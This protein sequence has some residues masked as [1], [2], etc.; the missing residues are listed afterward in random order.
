MMAPDDTRVALIMAGSKGLGLGC[1]EAL[2]SSGFRIAICARGQDGVD[3]A[4]RDLRAKG[5]EVIG[6]AA[7]VSR[8]DELASVFDVLDE[9][10]GRLD[11]LVVNAGGPKPGPFLGLG[12]ND[13]RDGFELTIM[14]A[15]RAI[16]LAVPRM[17]STGYGRIVVLGS[18]ST[19]LPIPNLALSNAFRPALDGVV[20]TLAAEL[21]PEGI[22]INMVCPGRIDTD[23]V[24]GLDEGRAQREGLTP[25]QVRANSEHSIPMGH[26]G[27][28]RDVGG[29]TAF[30]ASEKAGYI[31][32][33]CILVDG[34]M[35][36]AL[37]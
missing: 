22:T 27:Q 16:R 9:A 28:A 26:Y 34:G 13:W 7:D 25:G 19:R 36:L 23:R 1:A 33:Q 20:K 3:G 11:V 35:V 32:G 31:T 30:L 10:F 5:G 37:P 15:V 14:S 18:S 4:V 8:P 6:K 24:R 29:L 17:R 21:A 12:D 2:L